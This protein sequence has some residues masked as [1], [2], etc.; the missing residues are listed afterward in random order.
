[1][2]KAT[3]CHQL[4]YLRWSLPTVHRLLQQ[5][6]TLKLAHEHRTFEDANQYCG[7]GTFYFVV[8]AHHP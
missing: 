5:S 6:T 2:Y 1:M 7:V 8:P 3:L 4:P